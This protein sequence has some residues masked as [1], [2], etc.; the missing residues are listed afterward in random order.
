MFQSEANFYDD[1]L[2]KTR[3]DTGM[4]PTSCRGFSLQHPHGQKRRRSK[5][6]MR[7][8]YSPKWRGRKIALG[9]DNGSLI[10]AGMI[11]VWGKEKA[12]RY[13]QQLAKQEPALQAGA[14]SS[15]IQCWR[16]VNFP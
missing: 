10:L 13:F 5:K 16:A 8:S 9:T 4:P 14:P 3:K 2:E 1:E 6:I 7:T 15:R 11:R 12:V